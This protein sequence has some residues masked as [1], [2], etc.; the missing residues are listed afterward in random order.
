MCGK[1]NVFFTQK[2]IDWQ[3]DKAIFYGFE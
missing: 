3:S 2:Q 1:W